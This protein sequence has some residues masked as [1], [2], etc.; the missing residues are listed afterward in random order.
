LDFPS[1]ILLRKTIHC[2]SFGLPKLKN[3][4]RL[5]YLNSIKIDYSSTSHSSTS[6][7]QLYPDFKL[8][9]YKKINKKIK[10]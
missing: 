9:K 10:T 6:L 1:P 7:K 8:K 5:S 4:I 2:P 3:I